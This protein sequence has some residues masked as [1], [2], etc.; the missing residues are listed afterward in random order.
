[1]KAVTKVLSRLAS[2]A[3]F[4]LVL[5]LFLVLPFLSVSCE[6]PGVGTF[7][8]D[9]NGAQLAVDDES[10]PEISPGLA[11]A[12]EGLPS[13]E[14]SVSE[15][16][17]GPGVQVLTIITAFV[18]LAGAATPLIQRARVRL[19]GAAA[20]AVV[21]ATLVVVT[22]VVA[23]SNLASRLI[24]DM[25]A[26]AEELPDSQADIPST[27]AQLEEQIFSEIGFWLTLGGLL[28]ITLISV[29]VA[30][31]DK[32]RLTSAAEPPAT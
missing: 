24:E 5:L 31:K 2:P 25:L 29:G 8:A 7:E 16:L 27:T 11:E 13:E 26:D 28:L 6:V 23:R 30:V 22:Q 15:S 20:I 4:A 32:L 3:G 9:Y 21:A 1:M 18:M 12:I 14:G 19:L 10:E 17:P